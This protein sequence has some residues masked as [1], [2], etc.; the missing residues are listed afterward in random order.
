MSTKLHDISKRKFIYR[1]NSLTFNQSVA[2]SV[3]F[4]HENSVLR[5]ALRQNK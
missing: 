4:L 3:L 5:Y 1:P 2:T